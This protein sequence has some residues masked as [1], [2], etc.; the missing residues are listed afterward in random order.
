MNRRIVLILVI[1]IAFAGIGFY[2]NS[3]R[4]TPEIVPAQTS[5]VFF[6]QSLQNAQGETVP[7]SKW[8]GDVLVV[9]FWATWC[10]PCVEEMP[11]LE[12]MQHELASSNVQILGIGIDSESN[13]RSFAEKL[14]ISYPLYIAGLEGTRLASELGNRSGGLPFTL[15][16]DRNGEI[17]KSYLGRL[18]MNVLEKDIRAI[19]GS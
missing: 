4:L 13:I 17:N 10:P 2:V 14:D 7:M 9:N 8:K 15:L 18:D 19:A 1:A 16:I 5:S 11:E 12:A 6:R 3:E